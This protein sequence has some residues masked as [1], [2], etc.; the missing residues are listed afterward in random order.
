M[1][2]LQ[3]I[4]IISFLG[5][6][7]SCEKE[8]PNLEPSYFIKGAINGDLVDL[9]YIENKNA[10]KYIAPTHTPSY[11]YSEN[12]WA[13]AI[14]TEFSFDRSWH[15]FIGIAFVLKFE[16]QRYRYQ[17]ISN[18]ESIE[19]L[20]ELM[21]E[22]VWGFNDGDNYYSNTKS[23][24]VRYE[25]VIGN[26]VSSWY[27][28]KKT[29]DVVYDSLNNNVSHFYINRIENHNDILGGEGLLVTGTFSCILFNREN[30]ADSLILNNMEFQG[31]LKLQYEK[32]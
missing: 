6:F 18:I 11:S 4:A 24:T 7:F 13:E 1:K 9:E 28:F 10:A 22:N 19:H 14:G 30:P 12:Y 29:G 32:N 5:L 20:E 17:D 25:K 15:E 3:A 21:N 23:V 8:S 27:N 26:T 16:K 31:F 2:L